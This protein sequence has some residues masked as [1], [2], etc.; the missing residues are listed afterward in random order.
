MSIDDAKPPEQQPTYPQPAPQQPYPPP[1]YY[2]YP[3]PKKDSA[4]LII[5]LVVILVVLPVILSVVLYIMVIGL[6]PESSVMNTPQGA[7]SS[8]QVT[9]NTTAEATF[10]MITGHTPMTDLRIILETGTSSGGYSFPCSASGTVASLDSGSDLGTITYWDFL[11]DDEVDSGD[12]LYL[13]GLDRNSDYTIYLM[14][15][16]NG[17]MMDHEDFTTPP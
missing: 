12:M 11:D 2:A 8:V 3:P 13:T 9:G 15:A 7:F 10:A 17:E 5:I 1:Y 4:K 14:W 6:E 16:P